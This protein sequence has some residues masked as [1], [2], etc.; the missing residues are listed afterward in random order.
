M[1]LFFKKSTSPRRW[2]KQ[3]YFLFIEGKKTRLK[4]F[5]PPEKSWRIFNAQVCLFKVLLRME[6]CH[7]EYET[8]S[9]SRK[10]NRDSE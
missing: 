9:S 5:G 2:T 4:R 3:Y 8:D 6:D 1:V 10:L 7:E